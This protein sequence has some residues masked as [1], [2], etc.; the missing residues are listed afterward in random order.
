MQV[1]G[2]VVGQIEFITPQSIVIPW[3]LTQS[4]GEPG[5]DRFI[6]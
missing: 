3:L 2:L 6:Q 5:T 1:N 4:I